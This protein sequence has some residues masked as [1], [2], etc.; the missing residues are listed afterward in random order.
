[1]SKQLCEQS[2]LFWTDYSV[3]FVSWLGLVAVASAA[4]PKGRGLFV[5]GGSGVEIATCSI[6]ADGLMRPV[7]SPT[8]CE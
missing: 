4:Q 8:A 3:L 7:V 6:A 2:T 5:D 1:M